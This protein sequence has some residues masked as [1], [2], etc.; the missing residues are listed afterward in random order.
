MDKTMMKLVT[1]A[2]L[3]SIA[4]KITVLSELDE[5]AHNV[6]NPGHSQPKL[7]RAEIRAAAQKNFKQTMHFLD[8]GTK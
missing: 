6:L 3:G 4:R 1:Y 2:M 7:S 5:N 8:K